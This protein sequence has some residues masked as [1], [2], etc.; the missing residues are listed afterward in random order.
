[1]ER[2][3]KGPNI[4]RLHPRHPHEQGEFL[5]SQLVEGA[6]SLKAATDGRLSPRAV[7]EIGR[8]VAHSLHFAHEHQLL[9][10]DV[11]PGNILLDKNGEPIL[12]DWG[13]AFDLAD[14]EAD[15]HGA[16]PGTPL[17]MS[18]D[19]AEGHADA[20]S[21]VYSLGCS[22]YELLTGKSIVTV[23]SLTT[24]EGIMEWRQRNDGP[25]PCEVRKDVPFALGN[26][27]ARAMRRNPNDRFQSAKEMESALKNFGTSTRRP[28]RREIQSPEFEIT[29]RA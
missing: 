24:Y 12:I 18:H 21:D 9:H 20:R 2:L 1:M 27:V 26:L 7:A 16:T 13:M 4:L 29:L 10:R 22:L 5:L 23:D 17:Y 15:Q 6:G 19:Q 25:N 3:R 14:P 11:K 8:K 28:N